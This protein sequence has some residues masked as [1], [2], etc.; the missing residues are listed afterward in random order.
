MGKTPEGA[1]EWKA[2]ENVGTES[3]TEKPG[4]MQW[5]GD[6]FKAVLPVAGLMLAYGGSGVEA[7]PNAAREQLRLKE[8]VRNYTTATIVKEFLPEKAQT[9]VVNGQRVEKM[10]VQI[11][12]GDGIINLYKSSSRWESLKQLPDRDF[13]QE[14]RDAFKEFSQKTEDQVKDKGILKKIREIVSSRILN[15]FGNPADKEPQSKVGEKPIG[16]ATVGDLVHEVSDDTI[17]VY[18]ATKG[19]GEKTRSD[20]M[21]NVVQAEIRTANLAAANELV[22]QNTE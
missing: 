16:E 20:L 14:A 17:A 8:G 2:P 22:L 7:A 11:K 18:G 5:A 12:T 6:R 21:K 3:K 15:L 10:D 9:S 4:F 1:E 19:L 13:A